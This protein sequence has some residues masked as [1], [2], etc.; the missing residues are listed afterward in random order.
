LSSAQVFAKTCAPAKSSKIC[1]ELS[2][3]QLSRNAAS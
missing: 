3:L 1:P 2:L